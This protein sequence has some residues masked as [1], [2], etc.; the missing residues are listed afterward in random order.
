MKYKIEIEET[1]TRVNTYTVEAESEEELEQI[2]Y[3]IEDAINSAKDRYD[4]LSAIQE[5]GD[6]IIE[7]CEGE[8]KTEYEL[9]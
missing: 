1:I 9:L 2:V 4:V 5:T 7:F 8:E 6:G 3:A